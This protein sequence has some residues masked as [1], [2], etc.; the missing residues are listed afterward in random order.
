M[1][2][3]SGT[4]DGSPPLFWRLWRPDMPSGE[5]RAAVGLVHGIHEHSGRYAYLASRL[6]LQGIEVH[7]LDLRGHGE[8]RGA[9]GQIDAFSEYSVDVERWL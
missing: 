5:I 8:S 7:A 1:T 2:H 9:R 3:T 4:L 6:M